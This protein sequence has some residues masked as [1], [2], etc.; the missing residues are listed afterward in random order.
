[1]CATPSFSAF[2]AFLR[3]ESQLNSSDDSLYSTHSGSSVGSGGG[4]R[5][6]RS[7]S[8][9]AHGVGN[10]GQLYHSHSNPDLSSLLVTHCG[11]A[12]GPTRDFPEHVLKVYKSDQTCKYLL[13]HRVSQ[14]SIS[15]F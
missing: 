10:G 7:G 9:P 15:D 3:S 8:S 11:D 13:V 12:E 4:V 1:M 6:G 2:S 5:V 14:H